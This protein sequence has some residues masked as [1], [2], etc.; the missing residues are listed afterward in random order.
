[1]VLSERNGSVVYVGG[2]CEV[3]CR[4]CREVKNKTAASYYIGKVLRLVV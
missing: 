1:M 3:K 4:L 2:G